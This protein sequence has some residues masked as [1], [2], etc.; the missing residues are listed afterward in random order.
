Y[1]RFHD[2]EETDPGILRL[3]ELHAALDH[4]VLTAY[5]WSD[6]VETGSTICEFLPDYFDEPEEEGGDPVPKSIRYRW[7]DA[8]RDEVLARLL[9]L[10]AERHAQEVRQGLHSPAAQKATKKTATKKAAKKVAQEPPRPAPIPNKDDKP[11]LAQSSLQ[12]GAEDLELF[13]KKK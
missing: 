11:T 9:K 8:T 1:N 7:P 4:A 6:L 5:G 2:R 12:F 3:R 10:N 13:G